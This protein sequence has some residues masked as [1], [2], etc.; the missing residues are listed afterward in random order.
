MFVTDP[1][2]LLSYFLCALYQSLS[3]SDLPDYD[4]I[5]SSLD[6]I[7]RS[8]HTTASIFPSLETI[9]QEEIFINDESSTLQSSI[10]DWIFSE[11]SINETDPSILQEIVT[12]RC[13]HLHSEITSSSLFHDME[14]ILDTSKFSSVTLT[15]LQSF[16]KIWISLVKCTLMLPEK[17]INWRTIQS[18]Q[19]ILKSVY[20]FY[21]YG[22]PSSS[23]SLPNDE[24]TRNGES[25]NGNLLMPWDEFMSL[26]KAIHLFPIHFTHSSVV[27]SVVDL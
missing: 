18:L 13:N 24:N 6:S 14:T 17:D 11:E 3:Y 19:T 12:R 23:S 5:R 4:M 21:S 10:P 8:Q 27:H 26:Q 1:L 7:L 2:S 22:S 20:W 15:Q 25:S 16:P 9:L